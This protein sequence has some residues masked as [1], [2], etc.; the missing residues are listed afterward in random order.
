MGLIIMLFKVV[1]GLFLSCVRHSAVGNLQEKIEMLIHGLHVLRISVTP[2]LLM[3]TS[4]CWCRP[5]LH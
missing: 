5:K 1:S 3:I 2:R 4:D